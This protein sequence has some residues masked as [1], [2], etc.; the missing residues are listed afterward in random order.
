MIS[1][2]TPLLYIDFRPLKIGG[3]SGAPPQNGFGAWG[4][5]ENIFIVADGKFTDENN[6]I[7]T[8]IKLP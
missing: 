2:S 6:D 5:F 8:K 3:F 1:V 7:D 4:F